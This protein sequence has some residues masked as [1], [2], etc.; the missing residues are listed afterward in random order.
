VVEL[1]AGK[2]PPAQQYDEARVMLGLSPASPETPPAAQ[3]GAKVETSPKIEAIT[4]AMVILLDLGTGA[5]G[6][7]TSAPNRG[8]PCVVTRYGRTRY[9]ATAV[10]PLLAKAA[11]LTGKF[12]KALSRLVHSKKGPLVP[13]PPPLDCN[14]LRKHRT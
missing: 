4:L 8:D 11:E 5:I 14:F 7:L 9:S 1:T 12:F 13:S 3:G 2:I 6:R 10:T